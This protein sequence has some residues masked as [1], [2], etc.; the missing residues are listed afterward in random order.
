[1]ALLREQTNAG[2]YSTE[3]NFRGWWLTF[4]DAKPLNFLHEV[5]VALRF[6]GLRGEI[7]LV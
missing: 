3:N 6:P 4:G 5:P 2:A 1:M 7:G